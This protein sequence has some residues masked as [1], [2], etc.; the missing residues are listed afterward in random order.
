MNRL[1]ARSTASLLALATALGLAGTA[2]AA[3]TVTAD[4]VFVDAAAPEGSAAE[5]PTTAADPQQDAAA[6]PADFGKD[7]IRP[8]GERLVARN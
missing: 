5:A 7:E 8:G 6:A 1:N 2:N 4:A 3:V